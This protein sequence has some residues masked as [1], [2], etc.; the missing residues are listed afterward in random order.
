MGI[1]YTKQP[2]KGSGPGGRIV[3]EDILAFAQAQK[4]KTKLTSVPAAAGAP[5]PGGE[6]KIKSST[7]LKGIRKIIAERL[8][9]SSQN[10][11][12]IMLTVVPN[13]DQLMA[14]RERLKDKVYTMYQVKV[15]VTDFITKLC[16]TVLEEQPIMN[17]SLQNNNH[18][19]YEDINIGLA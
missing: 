18:I 11:P 15:T 5:S 2:I 19:M 9:Y 4:V 8:T 16:A 10:I 7:Q 14:L 6:I 13:V 12:H 3:K 1:D 17:S